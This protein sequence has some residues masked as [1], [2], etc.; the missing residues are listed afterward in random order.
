[1]ADVAAL[2]VTGAA[3]VAPTR[4]TLPR[5]DLELRIDRDGVTQLG[6]EGTDAWQLPWTACRDVRTGRSR[7]RVLVALSV[8]A[9]RFRWEI[10][11]DG[12]PGGADALE[13]AL[14]ELAGARPMIR[15]ARAT[16][17]RP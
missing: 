13:G 2:V 8:G 6:T 12:I 15:G 7:G 10:P 9:L 14:R 5:D 3:L 17:R 11:E 16:R 1:M 4:T